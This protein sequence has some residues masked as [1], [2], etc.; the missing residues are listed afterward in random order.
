MDK[1]HPFPFYVIALFRVHSLY[2]TLKQ[3]SSIISS[4]IS[5]PMFHEWKL[6]LP[7]ELSYVKT[8]A[9]P[10]L[11]I[12]ERLLQQAWVNWFIIWTGQM[13]FWTCNL[14]IQFLS[15]CFVYFPLIGV[16]WVVA[17]QQYSILNHGKT[18]CLISLFWFLVKLILSVNSE[19]VTYS[20]TE[21]ECSRNGSGW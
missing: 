2:Y 6:K 10:S 18:V 16:L 14:L 15:C 12:T 21:P 11:F 20:S 1:Y 13:G 17:N 7:L 19:E 4:A 3:P 8:L 5:K 9:R